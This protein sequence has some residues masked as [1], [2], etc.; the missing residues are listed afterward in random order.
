MAVP[1]S[2]PER[3]LP[4]SYQTSRRDFLKTAALMT[5]GY[6]ISGSPSRGNNR[7]PNEKLNIGI[8]GVNHRGADNLKGVSGENI[9][10]L[11]DIDD[12]YLAEAKKQFPKAK[13]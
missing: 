3:S 13:T 4:M 10:A 1:K 6:W 12:N 9:V 8:I 11:G 5:T 7:S 2:L